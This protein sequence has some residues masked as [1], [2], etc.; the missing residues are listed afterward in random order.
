MTSNPSLDDEVA[1]AIARH[2]LTSYLRGDEIPLPDIAPEGLERRA[3]VFVTWSKHGEL[4]GS[5]GTI[6]PIQ[7]TAAR[8]IA[9]NAFQAG[10][11]DPRFEPVVPGDVDE[12]DVTIDLL[13]RSR[14]SG[15]PVPPASSCGARGS[16]AALVSAGPQT[17]IALAGAAGEAA[18]FERL[19]ELASD[20]LGM[21]NG[22]DL[23][24]DV[25]EITR[26][27]A[28]MPPLQSPQI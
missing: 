20:A 28:P 18:G 9:F 10:V 21:T 2:A 4:R 15:D 27:G 6:T 14:P 19:V 7:S 1:C 11:C 16:V 3:G 5:M 25:L 22:G 8:E 17:S 23:R 26:F 24:V 13:G 12:L